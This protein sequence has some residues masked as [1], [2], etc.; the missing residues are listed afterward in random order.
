VTPRKSRSTIIGADMVTQSRTNGDGARRGGAGIA[1][2][3]RPGVVEA[4]GPR[5]PDHPESGLSR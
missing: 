5:L 3:E 4:I 2:R 1:G